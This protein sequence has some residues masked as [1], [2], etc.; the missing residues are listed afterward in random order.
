M[1]KINPMLD[2][3]YLEDFSKYE[4]ICTCSNVFYVDDLDELENKSRC[5]QC[6]NKIAEIN[7]DEKNDLVLKF[8]ESLEKRKIDV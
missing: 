7:E 1:K 6:E 4:V 8:T 2:Y 3:N 5:E